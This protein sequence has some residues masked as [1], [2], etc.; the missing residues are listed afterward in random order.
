MGFFDGLGRRLRGE[1]VFQPGDNQPQT[2]QPP[3]QNQPTQEVNSA[4]QALHNGQKIR[5]IV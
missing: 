1:P 2:S 3:Q 5:P 4:G